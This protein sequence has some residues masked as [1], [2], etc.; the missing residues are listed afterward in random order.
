MTPKSPATTADPVLG[1]LIVVRRRRMFHILLAL[2]SGII[3]LP[4]FVGVTWAAIEQT[5][6]GKS[7]SWVAVLIAL[8][9]GAGLLIFAWLNFQRARTKYCFYE[10]GAAKVRGRVLLTIPYAE[11]NELVFQILPQRGQHGQRLW[12]VIRFQLYAPG[13]RAIC[14]AGTF[15][16]RRV[17]DGGFF[18]LA[19]HEADDPMD[20]VKL[21][22][23]GQMADG[24]IA[25]LLNGEL[26]DWNGVISLGTNGFVPRKGKLKG[27]T[28]EYSRLR[29]IDTTE[30]VVSLTI[31]G[32][33]EKIGILRHGAPNFWPYFTVCTRLGLIAGDS[34][35]PS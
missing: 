20:T 14:F 32:S 30:Q 35:V 33:D 23:A 25:R 12:T 2:C 26:I 16:T 27:Q 1:Q 22:I 13:R 29:F 3:G 9:I 5:V 24:I 15:Q 31:D 18:S 28:V 17:Q 6:K 10:L 21:V 11:A 19:R 4:L 7:I 8:A 34:A